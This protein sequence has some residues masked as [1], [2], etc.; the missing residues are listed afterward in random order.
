MPYSLSRRCRWIVSALGV[1]FCA[2]ATFMPTARAQITPGDG[3]PSRIYFNTFPLYFDGDYRNALSAF[4]S[5]GRGGIK[6]ATSQWIDSICYFTMAGESYYQMGNLPAALDSYNSALKL[7][8]AFSD[9]MMRVQ[10]PLVIPPAITGTVRA[11]PWGQSKRG[12]RIGQFSETFL[13]GQGRIDN[14]AAVFRGGV[15]QQA[16]LFPVHA[17]EIV[18]CTSLAIRRRRELMGPV[19]KF[20]SL[21]NDLIDVLSRR[22]GPPNH[23][24]EAWVSVQLGCAYAA[25]G[26]AAQANTALQ[27]GVLAAGEYDHPL[28]ST[29]LLEL[30]RLALEAGDFPAAARYFEETTYACINFPNL[31][32]LEEAFRFGFL[33]HQLLNQRTPY[34]LLSPAIAWSKAQGYRQLQASLL[35]LAA[36]N[37]AV[38]GD[39]AQATSLLNNARQVVGRTDLAI[40]QLSARLNHLTALVSYQANNVNAG[41][42]ALAQ[43]LAF[44]RNGSLWMFQIALADRRYMGGDFSDRVGMI[45]YDTLLRDPTPADWASNPLE[46]LSLLSTPH[47]A[48]L[49]HWFEAALKNSKEHELAL[50][51]ADRARRHRFFSTLELGGRLLA[52]RWI[53]EGPPEL[54][55]ERAMLQRQDLLA[56]YPKYQQLSQQAAKI[57]AQL[58]A[59]PVVEEA[60]DARRDQAG[61]LA[62]LADTSQSQEVLLREIAVRH[63]PAEMIFP[64]L[65]KTRD[66]QQSLPEG[67]V[68][69]AFFATSRGTYAFLYSR[70]KYAAW[71]INSPAQ[72][73]KQISTM[74]R[75][76]GNFEQ[77]HEITPNDLA[78]TNWQTTAAKVMSLLLEKSNV[79]LAGKFEEIVIV[80]D[81]A[82][83]YLPFE[84]LF[85][86]K[87]EHQKSL[88]SQSRVRYAPTVGLA[89]PYGRSQKPR[90]NIG[91]VLGKLHPQD[92]EKVALAAFEQLS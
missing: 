81:G 38:L 68:L 59:K 21:T 64:P 84:A 60:I 92:D 4:L 15:V 46:C 91:V 7:Y 25:A 27:R 85:V 48:V 50:E 1:W 17:A 19:C 72:L 22:P 86:G 79:D 2:A 55:T 70:D 12:A 39:T 57:R 69:L 44:Q 11:T 66:V 33:A 29:A 52:L 87:G 8:V 51:I 75:E 73:Q 28:T 34:P 20:D 14:S 54:L 10:F 40:S 49:E 58:A 26:N 30:G 42:Q 80:P 18:R 83:W 35:L 41:D 5:E 78:R 61:K 16:V 74:L 77:N 23:W 13:M 47:G 37:M 71:H 76:I 62:S 82:L 45:L 31:G 43:A 90:P 63:E 67:Q 3:V 88:I 32:N 24:S 53:L 89:I 56:R 6:T 9:W 65:R 36:E